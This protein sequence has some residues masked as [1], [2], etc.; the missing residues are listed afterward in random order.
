MFFLSRF[1][2]LQLSTLIKESFGYS[3]LE[4]HRRH[5]SPHPTPIYVADVGH[6]P[7]VAS[8]LP[9]AQE[10]MIPLLNE[11]VYVSICTYIRTWYAAITIVPSSRFTIPRT[12]DPRAMFTCIYL[13][14]LK[15]VFYV[16]AELQCDIEDGKYRDLSLL[17][18]SPPSL[19]AV[20]GGCRPV[21]CRLRPDLR[22]PDL[23]SQISTDQ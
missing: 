18:P 11:C 12:H 7:V 1:Y 8:R 21:A 4:I 6:Q 14:L 17:R 3:P 5:D 16:G 10:R 22:I 15:N 20:G 9:G 2:A 23:R 19:P 13:S